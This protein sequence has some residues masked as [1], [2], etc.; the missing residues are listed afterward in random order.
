[1]LDDRRH[2]QAHQQPEDRQHKEQLDQR[3]AGCGMP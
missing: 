3:E 2:N 1:M